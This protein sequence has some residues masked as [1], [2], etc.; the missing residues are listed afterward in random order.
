MKILT[1]IIIFLILIINI[2]IELAKAVPTNQ[3][4]LEILSQQTV[5]Y[6]FRFAVLGDPHNLFTMSPEFFD[7]IDEIKDNEEDIS[8]IIVCGDLTEDGTYDQYFMYNIAINSWMESN[9]MPV[10]SLPGNH[11]LGQS[12]SFTSY[13]TFVDNSYD[14]YFEYGNSRFVLIHNVQ[15]STNE[16]SPYYYEITNDQI[17]KIDKWLFTAPDNRFT[18]AHVPIHSIESYNSLGANIDCQKNGNQE[19]YRE[20]H[21]LFKKHDVIA[22][23]AGHDHYNYDYK[24]QKKESVDYFITGGGGSGVEHRNPAIQFPFYDLSNDELF[25]YHWLEV[26]VTENSSIYVKMHILG[27]S[28]NSYIPGTSIKPKYF[29]ITIPKK[30]V[31]DSYHTT[32]G[33]DKMW[34]D[35]QGVLTIENIYNNDIPDNYQGFINTWEIEDNNLFYPGDF[36]GDGVEELLCVQSASYPGWLSMKKYS[37]NTWNW[38]WSSGGTYHIITPYK[39][40][41]KVGDFDGD[42]KDELFGVSSTGMAVFKFVNGNWTQKWHR[43]YYHDLWPYCDNLVVGDYD[44]DG[45]DEILGN[46]I[47][48]DG[49]ITMFHYNGSDWIWGWSNYGSKT[50]GRYIY[51]FRNNLTPGDFDGDGKDELF[52]VSS[53][54]TRIF[55]FEDNDWSQF[56]YKGTSSPIWTYRNNLMIYDYDGDGEDEILGKYTWITKFDYSGNDFIWDWSSY[57]TEYLNDWDINSGKSTYYFTV[58]NTSGAEH[59]LFVAVKNC[60][61]GNQYNA[62]MYNFWDNRLKS[63]TSPNEAGSEI[64]QEV[65]YS[66]K[67][68]STAS[69]KIFPNPVKDYVSIL[70]KLEGG[71]KLDIINMNGIIIKMLYVES[72]YYNLDCSDL[73]NGIYILRVSDSHITLHRRLIINK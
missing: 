44:N 33:W 28:R 35:Y 17:N 62:Y 36:N 46:D 48:N 51:N 4:A 63:T 20:L 70:S 25:D 65:N 3:K 24:Y 37:N 9:N 66:N 69:V 49:W 73:A 72:Q 47:D 8:F 53:Y 50:T 21:E 56:W 32:R 15:H 13:K 39:N 71:Y 11:D 42:G 10:F 60:N 34:S 31:E 38:Y 59:N 45:K 14:I 55:E 6:P 68:N 26:E 43:N 30:D 12:S 16:P 27:R 22:N 40:N 7:I 57:G 41:L 29:D 67:L 52:G 58:K 2:N 19:G 18:F 54:G 1:K 5:T 64:N 61:Q 23:F